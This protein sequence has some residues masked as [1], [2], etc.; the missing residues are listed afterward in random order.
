MK[1]IVVLGSMNM[2][3]TILA[4]PFPEKGETVTG[5]GYAQ[6][7]GG[8]GANQ[9][10]AAGRMGSDISFISACGND[11]F[12]DTLIKELK[13]SKVDTGS[14]QRTNL[15]TGIALIVRESD[16]DNRIIL[17][18]GSNGQIL[19]SIVE[20]LSSIISDADFLLLQLE[21]PIETVE[22]AADL[23]KKSGTTVILDPAPAVKL[24]DNLLSN[25]DYLLPNEHELDLV[26]G[27]TE[28]TLREKADYLFKKGVGTLILTEGSKGVTIVEKDSEIT[29]TAPKMKAIDTTAAG[30]TFAGAFTYGLTKDWN[31]KKTAKFAVKAAS[32][33]V[34]KIGAQSSIPWL[35]DVEAKESR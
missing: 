13:K 16:G 29:L 8:K 22:Y 11:E 26:L 35:K 7:P 2:D 4:T 5:S 21:I 18:E 20:P 32:L 27:N 24:S 17:A 31:M 1:K 12:G 10:V 34:T 19:P 6:I 30:D 33:S 25:I 28:G 15:H 23:A 3:L 9:A 14:I